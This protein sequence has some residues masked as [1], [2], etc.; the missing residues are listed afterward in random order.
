MPI[1]LLVT[2]RDGSQELYY[3]PMSETLG[4]KPVENESILRNELIA[5]P[6]VNPTYS[7]RINRQPEEISRIEIDPSQRMA[8]INRKN[9]LIEFPDA[10][11]A[12]QDSTR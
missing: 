11:K 2:F 8:D 7:L 4:N 6:W 10:F 9:N 3:V 1:D 5:W 12:Y